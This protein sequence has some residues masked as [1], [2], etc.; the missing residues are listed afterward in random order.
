MSNTVARDMMGMWPVDLFF[1]SSVTLLLFYF[2]LKNIPHVRRFCVYILNLH[3]S[4]SKFC[5]I[6][7]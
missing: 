7:M 6:G 5:M 2:I 1:C 3:L 4:N